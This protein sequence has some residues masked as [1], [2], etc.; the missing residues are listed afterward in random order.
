MSSVHETSEVAGQN[1]KPLAALCDLIENLTPCKFVLLFFIF[2]QS[3][4]G[5]YLRHDLAVFRVAVPLDPREFLLCQLFPQRGS[6][7]CSH[8]AFSYA[9]NAKNRRKST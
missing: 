1:Q 9:Q 2:K 5:Q 4:G 6:Q 8:D 3:V 7:V